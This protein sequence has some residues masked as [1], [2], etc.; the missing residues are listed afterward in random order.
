MF[1][2]VRL[3][4]SG[5]TSEESAERLLA[6]KPFV[7]DERLLSDPV[8]AAGYAV[9]FIHHLFLFKNEFHVLEIEFVNYILTVFSF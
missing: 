3:S 9:I 7:P 6:D 2:F 8:F 5:H 4:T 1:F